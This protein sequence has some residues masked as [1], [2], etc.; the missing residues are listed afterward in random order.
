M[1]PIDFGEIIDSYFSH[2]LPRIFTQPNTTNPQTPE[3]SK[4]DFESLFETALGE[5]IERCGGNIDEALS[6]LGITDS[7]AVAKIKEWFGWDTESVEEVTYG[8][9]IV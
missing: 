6:S 2:P 9:D 1:P 4:L 7:D 3:P 5:L 8:E